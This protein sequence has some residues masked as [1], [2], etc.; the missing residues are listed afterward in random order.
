M[1]W[2]DLFFT[3]ILLHVGMF[4]IF[5]KML[6]VATRILV[7]LMLTSCSEQVRRSRYN[8]Y[9]SRKRSNGPVIPLKQISH[10][11]QIS[12][13]EPGDYELIRY[14]SFPWIPKY[15]TR[16]SI[17]MPSSKRS[18]ISHVL[19]RMEQ[20]GSICALVCDHC[21]SVTSSSIASLCL[22]D[23]QHG[24]GT[25]LVCVAFWNT[26]YEIPEPLPSRWR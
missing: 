20:G 15:Q 5:K 22:G 23:C 18:K 1:Y 21:R 2:T 10:G 24:G 11:T 8:I 6:L 25:Y 19:E 26:R 16:E 14:S 9:M 3:T 7:I 4:F 13:Q 12:L 17:D